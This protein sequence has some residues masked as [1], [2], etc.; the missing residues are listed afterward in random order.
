MTSTTDRDDPIRHV[1]LLILENHSFD[2]M[3]GCLAEVYPG[4]DGADQGRPRSNLD[5]Q[6]RSYGQAP[7]TERQML[8]DPH[9]ELKHV[10]RQL[11]DHNAG[12]VEDFAMSFPQSTPAARQFI[13]GYYP[14]GFLP[15]LHALAREFTICDRWFSSLPGPTWPNRF[16][17]LSGTSHGRVDMPDDGTHKIDF[18]GYFEQ[19]QDTIFDRLSARG[20][21]WKAYFHDIPQSWAMTR[22]RRPE[23][24]ARYFYI[25]EFFDDARGA[26][27][28]FPDFCF[29]EPDY[30]GWGQNDDHPPHDVMRAEKLLADVYNALRANEALW[31][32]T[33][34]VVFFDEHGGFYDHVE[35]P[36]T[37]APDGHHKDYDFERL[38]VRVPALL[39]SPW[40]ERGVEHTQFDHT[41]LLKYLI[42]KWGLEELG[43]RAQQAK[44][45][46][47]VLA[48]RTP[49]EDTLV[50]IEL[51][52]EELRP[53]DTELEEAAFGTLSAHQT[54]LASLATF[55]NCEIVEGVPW[56]IS[57]AARLIEASRWLL[58]LGR[59]LLHRGAEKI[60]VSIAEPDKLAR[61]DAIAKD[62]IAH[63]LMRR[64]RRAVPLLARKIRDETLPPA[65]RAH[66]QHTLALISKRKFHLRDDNFA[67][68]KQWLGR[69][70]Y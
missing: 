64:K 26:E 13:M 59:R 50:R 47:T 30:L 57:R 54:S 49:R 19:T 68:A 61:R 69:H 25:D 21:H 46:G 40:V 31:R 66:A 15:A 67:A 14:L 27:A 24:A 1:V 38:G 42:D 39:V 36:T 5:P 18:A 35:P 34:L 23:R 44:S 65:E 52:P 48:R 37:I 51:S 17:A 53:P 3:V 20:R 33:L 60:R 56:I 10:A 4:L 12:F 22:Q 29:V 41:S 11:A 9:H 2:Q 16:F 62:D 55:V 7:T 63:A 8:L 28:E 6:G 70:G 43:A 45:I 32:S 58:G